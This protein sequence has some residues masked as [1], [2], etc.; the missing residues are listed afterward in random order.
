MKTEIIKLITGALRSDEYP[1]IYGQLRTTDGYCASAVAGDVLMKRFPYL[2]MQWGHT[3]GEH[4]IILGES[5]FYIEGLPAELLTEAGFCPLCGIQGS[6][7]GKLF[8]IATLNDNMKMSFSFLADAIE[9]AYES[10]YSSNR[11]TD[12]LVGHG[13]DGD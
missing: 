4:A 12:C 13:L 10:L 11:S 7:G 2:G 3:G 9:R 5:D 8:P 6:V 1:Q